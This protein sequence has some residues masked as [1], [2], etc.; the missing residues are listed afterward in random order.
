MTKK[1]VWNKKA[2]AQF[3]PFTTEFKTATF[4]L[5]LDELQRPVKS[6]CKNSE[7]GSAAVNFG[8]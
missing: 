8:Q 7:S 2:P 4:H 6:K 3:R 1:N 5:I